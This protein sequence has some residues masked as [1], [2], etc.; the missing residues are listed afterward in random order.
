MDI[1]DDLDVVFHKGLESTENLS[2]PGARK[3]SMSGQAETSS[4]SKK[5]RLSSEKDNVIEL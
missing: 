5:P 3:R 2:E 4:D 1:E